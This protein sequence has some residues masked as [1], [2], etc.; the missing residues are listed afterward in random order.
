MIE[1]SPQE[2]AIEMFKEI[3]SVER[4]LDIGCGDGK[5]AE[6]LKK[7]GLS[8]GI[9]GVDMDEKLL[10]KAK[11]KGIEVYRVD[12]E[13]EKLPFPD[14]FFDVVLCIDVIEHIVN[15]YHLLSEIKRVLKSNGFLIVSTPNVRFIYHI[16]RLILG[17]GPK[18]SFNPSEYYGADLYDG[19]HVHYFTIKDLRNLLI[20]YGFKL[21]EVRGTYNV[22]LYVVRGLS[23]FASKTKIFYNYLCPGIVTM[24][25]NIKNVLEK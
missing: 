21:L 6:Q 14:N 20:R 19:G 15:I 25:I 12:L 9:Y 13:N 16:I 24:A 2:I 17:Y 7:L 10:N 22:G 3:G 18:T 4:I 1:G 8:Q 5:V 11:E 23:K